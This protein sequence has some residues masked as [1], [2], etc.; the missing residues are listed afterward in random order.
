[1]KTW[2][3]KANLVIY[4]LCSQSYRQANYR[5]GK[6]LKH[7]VPYSVPQEAKDLIDCLNNN[8]EAGAKAMFLHNYAIEKL[9][10]N[11]I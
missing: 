8:D 3:D 6:P 1:M 7:H 11:Q 2:Q 4:G 5:D 10:K 9:A